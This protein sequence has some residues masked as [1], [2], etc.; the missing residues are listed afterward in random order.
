MHP[1]GCRVVQ[2]LLGC[3][4]EPQLDAL[5]DEL[6]QHVGTLLENEYGNYV[7]QH[8]LKRC[9]PADVQCTRLRGVRI[10]GSAV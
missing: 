7:C 4:S 6:Q 1:H 5:F 10:R 2:G 8:I 3:A 9:R